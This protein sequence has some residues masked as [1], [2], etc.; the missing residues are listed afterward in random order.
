MW[1][2]YNENLLRKFSKLSKTHSSMHQLSA[3]YYT[4]L[5]KCFGIPLII[6]SAV[7]SCSIF[8]T[9]DSTSSF[10]IYIN[11]SLALLMTC[12]TGINSLMEFDDKVEKH[13]HACLKYLQ[14][15]LDIDV[16]LNFARPDRSQDPINFIAKV[17]SIFLSIKKDCEYPPTWI[18]K[19]F[20]HD[21]QSGLMDL[22]SKVNRSNHSSILRIPGAMRGN[23]D[24]SIVYK[25]DHKIHCHKREQEPHEEM[26]NTNIN[27]STI[28]ETRH[29][30][31]KFC[32][33]ISSTDGELSEDEGDYEQ[34]PFVPKIK[35]NKNP[36]IGNVQLDSIIVESSTESPSS[37]NILETKS[38]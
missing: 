21:H 20:I 37:M 29:A 7:L 31:D 17:R 27:F 30:I 36:V 18:V 28:E 6:L 34:P 5:K 14:I 8:T 4:K 22:S 24:S 32:D 33:K 9:T 25:T 11:G 10:F 35:I 23:S 2:K 3:E 19:D 38:Q 13:K 15:N 16:I 26:E 12:L 1:T